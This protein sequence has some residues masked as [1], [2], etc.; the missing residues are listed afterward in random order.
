MYERWLEHIAAFDQCTEDNSW[1][2]L[3]PFFTEDMRYVVTGSPYC[4]DIHGRDKVLKGF[5]KSVN[6]F[7]RKFDKRDWRAASIKLFQP[8]CLQAHVTGTYE[9]AGKPKLQ[10]GVQGLWFF[11]ED[12]ICMMVD[13]YDISQADVVDVLEWP[14]TYGAEMELDASYV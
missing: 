12:R 11:R 4:C 2:R 5:E 3:E 7:D 14:E 13:L 10:F 6:G 9:I 1:A 8:S